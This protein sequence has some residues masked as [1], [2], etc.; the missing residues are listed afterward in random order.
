MVEKCR[1]WYEGGVDAQFW[2]FR[3]FG[4]FAIHVRYM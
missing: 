3:L 1:V 4:A 2:R